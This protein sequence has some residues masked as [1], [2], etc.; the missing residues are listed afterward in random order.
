M[1]G[2]LALVGGDELNPGNEPQDELLAA[3]AGT[4]P[5]YVIATAAARQHPERAAARA[6]G[7]FAQFG[8]DVREL[9][10][11]TRT[12]AKSAENIA[13]AAE[14]RFFYLVGGDPGLTVSTLVDTPLWEAIVEAWRTGAALA[15]SS[16]GAMAMGS[17]S[18]V[19][20]R[21]KGDA[22]RRYKDALGLVPRVAV[23]P[24]FE[25]FGHRWVGSA[26][27]TGPGAIHL[28]IDERSAAVRSDGTWRAMGPGGV[29][30]IEAGQRKRF[31]SG[32]EITG[33]PNPG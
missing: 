15:G 24:H 3:A 16:A 18:L 21:Y 7:W 25:T 28:G 27:A 6:H 5:A 19:R 33:L 13:L 1:E 23:A 32:E 26:Q 4:G 12:Q 2:P 14:G 31:E 20:G 11:R 22:Q 29:T 17:W 9:P 10:A 30:V 8:L